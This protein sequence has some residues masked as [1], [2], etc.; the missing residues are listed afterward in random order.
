MVLI[1]VVLLEVVVQ[2]FCVLFALVFVLDAPNIVY[3]TSY[4]L[5]TEIKY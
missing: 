1:P 2:V 3:S 4:N 5:Y